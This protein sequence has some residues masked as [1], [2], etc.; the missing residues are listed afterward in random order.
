MTI[1]IC[2]SVVS[3]KIPYLT[4]QKIG[5]ANQ[6]SDGIC[7]T[8]VCNAMSSLHGKMRNPRLEIKCC[9]CINRFVSVLWISGKSESMFCIKHNFCEVS[10]SNCFACALNQMKLLRGSYLFLGV[11]NHG[12][13]IPI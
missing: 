3:K 1:N 2:F 9:F 12:R 5:F 6:S 7:T 11:D 4:T 10:L 13:T 8:V